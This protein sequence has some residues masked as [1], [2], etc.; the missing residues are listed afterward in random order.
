MM[1]CQRHIL[2]LQMLL[3]Y[4]SFV[5]FSM[6]SAFSV[7]HSERQLRRPFITSTLADDDGASSK[8][9]RAH[10]ING[11]EL[12]DDFQ[13]VGF[14]RHCKISVV[15]LIASALITFPPPSAASVEHTFLAASC[16][17]VCWSSS[18]VMAAV[19]LSSITPNSI[20]ELGLKS[21]TEEKPQIMLNRA[22]GQPSQQTISR[23]TRAP[24][25]QG[26]VYF[27]QRAPTDPAAKSPA[28]PQVKEQLDYY[29]DILVLTAVSAAQPEAGILAGAKFP[30]S[31]VRFPF[32]FEMYKENLLTSRPG[33]QDAWERVANTGDIIV[34]AKICPSDATTFPCEEK[35]TKKYA[36]GVAKLVQNLPGLAEGEVIRAPASLALH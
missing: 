12:I 36:E 13:L 34:S 7:R 29:S 24:I 25:L 1:I 4:A 14:L 35:E 16:G 26:L 6:T 11:N 28:G 5:L 23:K 10:H 33:V 9:I 21:P 22:G 27:P 19:D 32:S 18:V 8:L 17:D 15:A 3:L 20:A 2:P 30:V 31:S